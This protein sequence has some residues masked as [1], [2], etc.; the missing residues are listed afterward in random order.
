PKGW[1]IKNLS[2]IAK[3]QIGPFGSQLHK[4]DYISGGIPLINPTHICNG[5]VEPDDDL[6]I[7]KN[8]YM[9]LP[10]YHLKAGDIVMGRRGEM[11]RCALITTNEDGW[12]CGTGSLYIRPHADVLFSKYLVQLLSGDAI[13]EHLLAASLG[14]TM[15]NLNKTIIGN[16]KIPIP[17]DLT[18]KKYEKFEKIHISLI[19]NTT[20]SNENELFCSLS[21]KAFSGQL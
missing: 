11:G 15:P 12:F 3:I 7:A 6:T 8:M 5:K 19:K 1:E 4:E 9:S 10:Q 14:A 17:N 21:Q 2:E 16:I 13:K 18:L 20:N